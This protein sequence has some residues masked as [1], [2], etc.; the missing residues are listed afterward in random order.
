MSSHQQ[1]RDTKVGVRISKDTGG[2][3]A[4]VKEVI[5]SELGRI[6]EEWANKSKSDSVIRNTDSKTNGNGNRA[7]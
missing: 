6:R 4:D 3:Y 5:K 1:D 7:K 2:A